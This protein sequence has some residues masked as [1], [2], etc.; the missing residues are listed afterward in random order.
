MNVFFYYTAAAIVE[1]AGYFSLGLVKV[2]EEYLLGFPGNY[3][4][5][6]FS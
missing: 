4:S 2:G 3:L 6:D 5:F 1:I